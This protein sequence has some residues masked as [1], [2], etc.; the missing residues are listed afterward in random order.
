[1]KTKKGEHNLINKNTF[2]VKQMVLLKCD[3]SEWFMMDQLMNYYNFILSFKNYWKD[4]KLI[5]NESGTY[6]WPQGCYSSITF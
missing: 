1:M 3:V 5:N 6:Y 2:N 4:Q